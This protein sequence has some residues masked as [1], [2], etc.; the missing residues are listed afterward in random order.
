LVIKK[1]GKVY[2]DGV[3]EEQ[4]AYPTE[5]DQ[6][7]WHLHAD[8]K[9][10][11]NPMVVSFYLIAK[12]LLHFKENYKI[13]YELWVLIVFLLKCILDHSNNI[14]FSRISILNRHGKHM[15]KEGNYIISSIHHLP[16]QDLP[17]TKVILKDN[18]FNLSTVHSWNERILQK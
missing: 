5:L 17:I 14:I 7:K 3:V 15:V 10:M 11:T 4:Q 12:P 18:L 2:R 16:I 1:C 8:R 6:F 9:P 13:D